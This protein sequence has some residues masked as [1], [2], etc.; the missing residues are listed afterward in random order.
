MKKSAGIPALF[1]FERLASPH[2]N[3]DTDAT[4]VRSSAGA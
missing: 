4:A 3:R 1:F 2:A